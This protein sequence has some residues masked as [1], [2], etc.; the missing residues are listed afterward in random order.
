MRGPGVGKC[1]EKKELFVLFS[2]AGH[3][4]LCRCCTNVWLVCK[5][6]RLRQIHAQYLFTQVIEFEEDEPTLVAAAHSE[7]ASHAWLRFMRAA[8][9]PQTVLP[10]S[11]QD[12]PGE[13]FGF[14][15]AKAIKETS[16]SKSCNVPVPM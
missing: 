16:T 4:V 2:L 7:V 1:S 13:L 3:I 14:D 15:L 11:V 8:F 9:W 10:S 6:S 5:F 12:Q